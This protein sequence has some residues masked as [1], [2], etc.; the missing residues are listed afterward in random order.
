[1]GGEVDG[2]MSG[3]HTDFVRLALSKYLYEGSML[4]IGLMGTCIHGG[5]T[6]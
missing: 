2:M 5:M 6:G 3:F 4:E 1:M